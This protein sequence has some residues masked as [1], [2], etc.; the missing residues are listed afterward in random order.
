MSKPET[1][2]VRIAVAVAPDGRWAAKG[3]NGGSDRRMQDR[4]RV[5]LAWCAVSFHW[6]EAPMCLFL[7]PHR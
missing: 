1:V 6:I 3:Y 4:A 2:R 5:S 7:Y